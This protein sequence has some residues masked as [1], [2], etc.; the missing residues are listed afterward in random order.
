MEGE[1]RLIR[2]AEVESH[3]READNNWT[4]IHGKVYDVTKFLDEHPGGGEI[5]LEN[6]GIDSSEAFDDVGHS[7]DANEMLEDLLVG[8]LHPDDKKDS[9][10][11]SKMWTFSWIPVS[12][13]L[14]LSIV[15]AKYA[16]RIRS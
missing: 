13:I 14:L 11:E 15:I 2:L 8:Y 7:K 3:N 1:K 16:I 6:A 5:L 9:E 10:S 4:L 12:C